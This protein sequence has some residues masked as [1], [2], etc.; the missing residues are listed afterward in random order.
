MDL[1]SKKRKADENDPLTVKLFR[2]ASAGRHTS[3]LRSVFSPYGEIKEAIVICD[4]ITGKSKGYG[5]VTYVHADAAILALKEPSKK[6]DGRVTVTNLAAAGNA[7]AGPAAGAVAVPAATVDVSQRKV[8]VGNVPYDMPSD[9]LLSVFS[10]FGEIEE[11]P[12]GFDKHTGKFR[13][14]ALFV[15][16]TVEG[17]RAAVAE[18]RRIVDGQLM[19]VKYANEGKKKP[20]M[21][22]NKPATVAENKP[23]DGIMVGR[24]RRLSSYGRFYPSS[25]LSG[26]SG[27]GGLGS[28]GINS[29]LQSSI[30]S[31]S[32]GQVPSSHSG[33]AG[34]GSF[35]SGGGFGGPY[36][37]SS[38]FSGGS[39]SGGYGGFGMGSSLYNNRLPAS[40][41]GMGSGAFSEGGP[42]SS[43]G[44]SGQ[45]LQSAGSPPGPRIP[46]GGG[47]YQG[48]PPY[49]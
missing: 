20:G 43:L 31:G 42:Y 6:I 24:K 36:G 3:L 33:G 44:H 15:Y 13:G 48:L 45:H 11:G 5:F 39:G 46:S 49:Y 9:R 25:A 41:G 14:Y 8:F 30:G 10:S 19:E 37:S 1:S 23:V 40:S 27:A 22:D 38:Q 32:T 21:G 29:P 2:R 47:M 17:A 4:K 35:G 7:G 28:H 34:L 18:P 12:L 26:F 16:K